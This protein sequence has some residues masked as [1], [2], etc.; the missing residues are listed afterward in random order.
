MWQGRVPTN[1]FKISPQQA[2]DGVFFCLAQWFLDGFGVW[3]LLFL[4]ELVFEDKHFIPPFG[5]SEKVLVEE[6]AS[7]QGVDKLKG[8]VLW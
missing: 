5:R 6:G 2:A 1:S 7:P 8:E 4:G 3:L